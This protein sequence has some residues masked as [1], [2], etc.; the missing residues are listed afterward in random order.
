MNGEPNE[1]IIPLGNALRRSS[2][3][4]PGYLSAGTHCDDFLRIVIVTLFDLAPRRV[5]LLSLQRLPQGL[6]FPASGSMPWT[7]SLFHWSSPYGGRSLTFALPYGVRTFLDARKRRDHP[8][9]RA[10][11]YHVC[12]RFHKLTYPRS[13]D[14][15][16][17]SGYTMFET[18][19]VCL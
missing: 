17:P 15:Q 18:F 4:Q 14:G 9:I 3:N 12:R 13:R 2:S 7:F 19:T 16:A 6:P 1:A 10:K 5:W 11:A 8:L